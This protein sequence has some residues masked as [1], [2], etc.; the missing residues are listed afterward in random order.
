M[1]IPAFQ[2]HGLLPPGD[3]PVSFAEL[4]NSLLVHGTE[5]ASWDSAWRSLLVDNLRVLVRQLWRV[6]ITE[7][8]VDGSFAE[9]KDHPNDIDGYFECDL[10]ELASGE[11]VR[12]LN[13]L[14]PYK[15]WT[16]DPSPGSPAVG[17]PKNNCRCGIDTVSNSIPMSEGSATTFVIR[18]GMNWN[19][20]PHFVNQGATASHEELS[21]SNRRV[22]MI[23]NETE[24]Q[25][26]SSRLAQERT[27]ISEHKSRLKEA[28][29]NDE[30]IRRVVDPFE[31]FHMQLVE[32][33]ESY[34]RLK[35]GEFEELEN[36]RG[37]GHLLI[38]LRIAR[39]VSQ[40]D[41]AKKLGVHE[42]QISR[43]E[44]N[45]YFGITLER[46]IKILE[47]LNVR[48]HTKVDVEPEKKEPAFAE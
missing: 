31:S 8:F 18:M 22:V 15:I 10:K 29:L 16:W 26:A 42:S 47:A 45:E 3:Y 24:Y 40:R 48:L 13:L 21:K 11:L 33:V 4:V 39:G 43:D 32:E 35:R 1:I 20:R 5:R 25:N 27:R 14:D 17:T 28:G 30:E 23:R 19:F 9:D 7:I 36:F 12:K 34:E 38:S 6:G 44:R 46:A 2:E 41:L 37:F